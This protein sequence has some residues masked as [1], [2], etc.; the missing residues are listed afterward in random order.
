MADPT[1]KMDRI[2]LEDEVPKPANPP[3]GCYFHTRCR[4]CKEKCSQESPAFEEIT[5]GHFAACHYAREL[6]LRGFDYS[7]MED[8]ADQ[9]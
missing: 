2:P 7:Q 4:Y 9:A 8:G 5:P 3:S 1:V 6:S